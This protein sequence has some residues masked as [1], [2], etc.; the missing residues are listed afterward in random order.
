MRTAPPE[1]GTR[2]PAASG[3]HR[4]TGARA[5][6]RSPSSLGGG[7]AQS[8]RRRDLADDE[9]ALDPRRGARGDERL[10]MP[11]RGFRDRVEDLVDAEHAQER[12]SVVDGAAHLHTVD[13][14]PAE[15][16]V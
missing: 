10:E 14:A 11:G 8:R 2:S 1:R 6:A 16:R 12:V 13:P 15:T 9:A 5:P 4:A 7:P 3:P